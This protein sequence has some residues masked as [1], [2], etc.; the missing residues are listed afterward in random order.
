L[1]KGLGDQFTDELFQAWV[2]AFRTL[3]TVMK[4]AAYGPAAAKPSSAAA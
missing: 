4:E 3:A 1:R 2:A